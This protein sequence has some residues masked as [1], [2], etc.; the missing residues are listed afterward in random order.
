MLDRELTADRVR[1]LLDYDPET[2]VLRWR[3]ARGPKKAGSVAGTIDKKYCVIKIDNRGYR[4]HRLA[5]L[6]TFGEWP[7]GVIDHRD[8][9][10]VTNAL[11]NLRDVTRAVNNENQ[12]RARAD[13]RS[14]MLGVTVYGDRFRARIRAAGK[15]RWLGIFDSADA[16]HAA[17][18]SAKRQLHAG[19]TI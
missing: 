17:Y 16:A 8:G 3:V 15:L 5:W 19:C 11:R 10:G 4:A 2:G 7:D 13:S 6:H 14:G 9:D 12:R 1:E 18:L